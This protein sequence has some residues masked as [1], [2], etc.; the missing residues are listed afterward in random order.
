MHQRLSLIPVGLVRIVVVSAEVAVLKYL[1]I[2]PTHIGKIIG[3]V[4]IV[5]AGV[6]VGYQERNSLLAQAQ[7]RS[8]ENDYL[9][10]VSLSYV[11]TCVN[12]ER[13]HR[14]RC[15]I[16]R[17]IVA[18]RTAWLSWHIPRFPLVD[19]I[20]HADVN[21]VRVLTAGTTAVDSVGQNPRQVVF[22]GDAED[23]RVFRCKLGQRQIDSLPRKQ[24][25]ESA[26]HHTCTAVG[27]SRTGQR[28]REHNKNIARIVNSKSQ[29]KDRVNRRAHSLNP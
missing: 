23:K 27:R 3:I 21:E 11:A 10:V 13:H 8:Y 7:E 2:N 16:K 12:I 20:G 25:R 1:P 5:R 17:Y 22:M 14:T 15:E 24:L 19:Q 9:S 6:F 29:L 26:R 18:Q 4:R 28:D